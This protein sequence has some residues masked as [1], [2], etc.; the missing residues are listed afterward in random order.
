MNR[1]SGLQCACKAWFDAVKRKDRI[2]FIAIPNGSSR[3]KLEAVRL[4]REGVTPGAPDMFLFVARRPYHGLAI[5]FKTQ[6]LEMGRDGKAVVHRTYQSDAQKEFQRKL[7]EQGFCYR[8]VRTGDEFT[9]VIVSYY[10]LPK[11]E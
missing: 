7:E 8:V 6:R 1:E 11:W 10:N 2:L 4:K 9:N 5:E 3:N